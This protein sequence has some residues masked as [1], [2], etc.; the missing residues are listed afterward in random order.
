MFARVPT[1][2]EGR[3]RLLWMT[4]VTWLFPVISKAK[5]LRPVLKMML[6]TLYMFIKKAFKHQNILW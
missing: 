4:V 3:Q 6:V 1:S 2:T 5:K